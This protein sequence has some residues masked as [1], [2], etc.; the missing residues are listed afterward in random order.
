VPMGYGGPHAAF[1]ATKEDFKRQ[2]PGRI[3]GVSRDA[4]GRP[5]LRM[6][7][8]T[9][10]QHIRR[11]KATS[12][13]CTA[14]VLLAV[15]ASMY[16][17]YHGP[18]GL[19]RIAERVHNLTLVL[20][21]GARRLGWTG[22]SEVFFDTI[23]LTGR[24]GAA[25]AALARDRRMNL[26]EYE[27]GAVGI[28]LDETVTPEEVGTLL[29]V[30]NGGSAPDFT[31]DDLANE[32]DA[33]FDAPFARTSKYMEHPVFNTHRSETEML[34]Y[35]R[36]LEEKDL[37]LV[38]SMIALGSCT[39]KL[40]ATT[41]M[42]P[43]TMSGFAGLHPFAPVAQAPGYT[44]LFERLEG[45]LAEITGFAGVSLQPNAGS[46]GEFAGLQVIKSYHDSRGEAGRNICLIPQSA[47]GTN[48]ASAVMAGMK[49]VVVKT[50]PN[51][52]IDVEDLRKRAAE[53]SDDLAAL[54]VTYPSTHGVF[55]EA[56][57]G[58]C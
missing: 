9:R 3:I 28:A 16:A 47:H 32:V 4:E 58:I 2:I 6:A 57:R 51:G 45:A 52:N 7:L 27:D 20:A 21:A 1:F 40:N 53:H 14:Q 41:E 55:E 43:I 15:M 22:E 11:E 12:N 33:G 26:R 25:V 17:V 54:M 31:V 23:R 30:L 10:E 56:I 37:S 48:P 29:E 35:I 24:N 36:S 42:L 46:Q 49:V 5:A 19:R 34:R 39:M 50:D 18:A 38:H 13:V 44:E 8:Q